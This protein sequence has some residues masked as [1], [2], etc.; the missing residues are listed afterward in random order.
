MA[1]LALL[2]NTVTLTLQESVFSRFNIMLTPRGS[3]TV[4]DIT[5]CPGKR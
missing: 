5:H 2:Y 3:E 1:L 4:V